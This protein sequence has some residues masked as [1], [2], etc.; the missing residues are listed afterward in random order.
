MYRSGAGWPQAGRKLD[1]VCA[2]EAA[3]RWRKFQDK[4][5][6]LLRMLHFPST[7]NTRN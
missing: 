5:N 6:F 7:A 3:D 2:L 1:I 4:P